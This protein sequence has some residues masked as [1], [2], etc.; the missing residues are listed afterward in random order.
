MILVGRDQAPTP[1]S[2]NENESQTVAGEALTVGHGPSLSRTVL[3]RGSLAGVR[4]I[5]ILRHRRRGFLRLIQDETPQSSHSILYAV[6]SVASGTQNSGRINPRRPKST[7]FIGSPIGR[8]QAEVRRLPRI[9]AD[10]A[11]WSVER[12]ARSSCRS[13]QYSPRSSP[14]RKSGTIGRGLVPGGWFDGEGIGLVPLLGRL[15]TRERAPW[16]LRSA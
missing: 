4:R 7:D 10:G 1:A 14:A 13:P 15:R 8:S 3:I 12:E 5:G 6:S 16:C 2:V 11:P 9:A